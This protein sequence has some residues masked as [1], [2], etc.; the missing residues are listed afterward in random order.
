MKK[1]Q[2]NLI[3]KIKRNIGKRKRGCGIKLKELGVEEN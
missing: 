1:Q 2:K 3:S